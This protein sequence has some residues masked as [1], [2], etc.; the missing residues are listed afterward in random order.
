MERRLKF[1]NTEIIK[2]GLSENA[3]GPI[4]DEDGSLEEVL[5]VEQLKEQIER[6]DVELKQ[7]IQNEEV[8]LKNANSLRELKCVLT[9]DDT[10]FSE[11]GAG[12]AGE[13]VGGGAGDEEA[14]GAKGM[15][16]GFLTGVVERK[17]MAQAA[18]ERVLWRAMRGNLYMRSVE[19]DEPLIDPNSGASVDKN[20][21]IIFF[22]GERSQA[23]IK[24]ICESFQVNLYTVPETKQGR[25]ALSK[26]I[27]QRLNDL[28]MVIR[29]TQETKRQMLYDVLQKMDSWRAKILKEKAIYHTMNMFNYDIGRKCLI[30][31]GWCPATATEEITRALRRATQRSGALVPSIL[32]F[33]PA[34]E[35]PPT[36]FRVNAF[37]NAFQEIVNAYGIP[38][39]R[40]INPTPFSIITFPFLFGVMFGDVGHG[41]LLLLFVLFMFKKEKEWSKK[42]L[43]ELLQFPFN[44]RYLMLIMSFFG[45]YMGALY[46]ECFAVPMNLF[47]S[48]YQHDPNDH[49]NLYYVLGPKGMDYVYPFGVDP[50][51]KGSPS[52]LIYY[53]SVK[54][55]FSIILGVIQ[56]SLGILLFGLNAFYR[57]DKLSLFFE[58][59]PMIVFM[60]SIFGYMCFLIFYKWIHDFGTDNPPFLL[61]VIINMFLSPAK[62]DYELYS[63]QQGVQNFLLAAALIA[64]PIMLFT[65]PCVLKRQ[66]QTRQH[67]FSV[68]EE[69]EEEEHFEFGEVFIHQVIHTIEFTLGSISNTASYLRLWALSLAHSELAT[70]F[71]DKILLQVISIGKGQPWL[72]ILLFFAF[73]MWAGGTAGVLLVMESLSAFLHGLRLHW[74]EFQNKFYRGDG[75]RFA[76]LSYSSILKRGRITDEE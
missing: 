3:F 2:M 50:A 59:I 73:H 27:K 15:Q 41:V 16:L 31:E 70:V 45:I 62:I 36:Y 69:D 52:E 67:G 6:L 43:H 47:G 75:K 1:F 74:V 26:E 39:Y 51:W 29:T 56:M 63:G 34:K 61:P 48:M 13:V 8:L 20:V 60:W 57:R 4:M 65:K 21:I 66:N 22:Q 33:L 28:D 72:F 42:Q 7:I 76:P 30:A 49:E 55:K 24:K 64:V 54:M 38:H 35:E 53:N 23:K 14:G 5:D 10:F 44:G 58:F 18:F 12:G 11:S 46:N 32:T 17:H 37:T 68:V 19:L 9:E 71:L 40:E 25:K